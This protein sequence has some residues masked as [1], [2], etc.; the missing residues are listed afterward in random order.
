LVVINRYLRIPK[1]NKLN[2]Y[3]LNVFIDIKLINYYGGY[4]EKTY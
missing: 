4:D 1:R 2:K 3:I